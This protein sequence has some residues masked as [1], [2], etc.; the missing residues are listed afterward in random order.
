[1]SLSSRFMLWYGLEAD[2]SSGSGLKASGVHG[3]S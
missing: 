2:G 1:M 3:Q